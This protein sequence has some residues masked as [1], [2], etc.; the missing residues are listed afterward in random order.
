MWIT[1]GE[2]K[3]GVERSVWSGASAKHMVGGIGEAV[4]VDSVLWVKRSGWRVKRSRWRHAPGV[5]R[6]RA[7]SIG[8]GVLQALTASKT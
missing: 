3:D 5:K 6:S 4:E 1:C 8:G 7:C 2:G